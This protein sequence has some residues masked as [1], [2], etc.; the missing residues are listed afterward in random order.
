MA[1]LDRPLKAGRLRDFPEIAHP[2]AQAPLR[3][4]VPA[5]GCLSFSGLGGAIRFVECELVGFQLLALCCLCQI[6]LAIASCLD[7]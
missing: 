1:V 7:R 5:F 4:P 3:T 2:V 6:P